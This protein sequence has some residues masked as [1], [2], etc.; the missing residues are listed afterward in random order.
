MTDLL[1]AFPKLDAVFAIND[2]TGI[3]CDLA[4]N[5]ARRNEF[6]HRGS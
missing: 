4:A 6:S 3:G 5:Q 2:P 1:T